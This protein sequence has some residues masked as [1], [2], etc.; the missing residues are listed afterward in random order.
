V[1]FYPG[2]GCADPKVVKINKDL[3]FVFLDSQWWFQ[4]WSGEKK[5]NQGCDIQSKHDLLKNVEEILTDHKNDEVV[6]LMHHPVYSNGNHGGRFSLKDHILPFQE[7]HGVGVP[8]PVIGSLVPIGRNVTGTRQDIAH[9]HYQELVSGIEAIAL[10]LR[11]HVLFASAHDNGLQHFSKG[12][13][14]YVVSGSGSRT[15]HIGKGGLADFAYQKQGFCK[16]RFYEDFEAWLEMY[17]VSEST[18]KTELVYRI[19]IRPARPGTTEE[20]IKYPPIRLADTTLAANPNFTAKGLKTVFLGEQYRD[21][22]TTPVK[23]P[24]IDL[25]QQ[26]GGLTPIKKGGGMASNSLRMQRTDGRQYILRSIN[27]D[28]RKVVPPSFGNLKLLNVMKDQNSAS[29]PYGALIIPTLSKAAGIYYTQPQLVYLKHQEGLGNYNAQFPEELYLLEERPSGD[30]GMAEQFGQSSKI[31]GYT[32]LL[33]TLR[34]KKNHFVDQS[35]VCRSRVFDLLIHDWD[36]HDDQWRWATFEEE[37]KTIYRPIPRDRDQAFYKFKGIVP[38]YVAL[39]LMKKFKTMKADVKDVKNLSF[40]AKHFDRYFMNELTWEDWKKEILVLQESISDEVIEA[41]MNEF[42]SEIRGINDEELVHKLKSRRDKLLRIGKKL[43]D[44][45]SKEVEVTGTDHDDIFEVIGEA[46]GRTSVKVYVKRKAKEPLL[47]YERVFYPK[48]TKEIRLY[49][50]RGQDVF[51]IKGAKKKSIAIRVIGGEGDYQINNETAGRK[52]KVYDD[53]TGITMTGP[54]LKD[55][56]SANVEVNDY[57]RSEFTYN[58]NLP[59]LSFGTTLDDGFWISGAFSWT[60]H[61]WRKRPYQSRQRISLS[62]APGSQDAFQFSY[63][64]HFPGLVGRLG[65]APALALHSPRYEN[66]F[67]LGN[68]SV[69]LDLATEFNWVRIQ[70]LTLSPMFQL[71]SKGGNSTFLFGPTFEMH[72]VKNTEGR[73]ASDA[74]LGFSEAA[75]ERQ[76]FLGAAARWE[77]G[78]VNGGVVPA[79][80]FQLGGGISYLHNL[81]RSESVTNVDVNM[82]F[83]LTVLYTP[84]LVLANNLGYQKVFGDP[85]FY[86]Y[87]DLGNNTNLRGFRNNRFRGESAFYQNVDLRLHLFKWNNN[88]LPMDVGVLGGFD[89]GR[90]WLDDEISD[91]WHDSQTV[92]IWM[93]VLGIVVLQPYYSFTDDGN[94]FTFR[95]GFSF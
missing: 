37:G 89:Y 50:L 36:R 92:G 29:H 43:Y 16:V 80:G 40:N 8:L 94:T 22:W 17:T 66:Y 53:L 52:V 39:F 81:D 51:T 21:I 31:I 86:Q 35:W 47:K 33:A 79:N 25:Q 32:D 23:A 54:K 93:N 18:Q 13:L 46:D 85:Q 1:K 82:Q 48:E 24:L 26:F 4:D 14:Q 7:S 71:N 83:Y 68:N 42:P 44:F 10:K 64:G 72:D 27:K 41:S 56:R 57:N 65:F 76:N 11:M 95:M 9:A 2:K 3:V 20:P 70:S 59:T 58:T 49:G 19:Q 88:F 63:N 73:V 90:V 6:L 60:T 87:A 34:A 38:G 12:K 15:Y 67:G 77:S 61:A 69:N 62:V 75:F 5:I 55:R 74:T 78:F 84:Q 45:I 91:K 30:W 28:Y